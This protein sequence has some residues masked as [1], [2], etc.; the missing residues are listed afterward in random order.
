MRFVWFNLMPWPDLPDD[1]RE[2]Y[3]S[4]WVDIPSAL[5]DP[6]RGH[7]VYNTYLDQ[8]EFAETVGFDGLGVN[9]HHANAYG[10]MPSPCL[11]AAALA[12]RTSRAA[13][14]V[15]GSSI[16]LYE[17]PIRVAEEFAMLDVI[18]G[19]RLV[20]GFPVGTSMDTN[21][22][23]GRVPASLRERYAEATTSFGA[24]GRPT[25]LSSSTVAS[26]S[27]ATPIA[28]RNRCRS[29]I[30]RSLSPAA[31]RL[32]PTISASRTTITIPILAFT[33]ICERSA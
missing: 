12:R 5:Y 28:G 6:V 11:M 2:K 3:R 17:P 1:F 14:V 24:P 27:C 32:R 4:V 20:A 29:R 33:A 26:P 18:S 13:L 10:L 23:Y 9:E 15:L 19:G 16:A 7:E 31:G 30:R 25:S 8:L 21:Y 22:A